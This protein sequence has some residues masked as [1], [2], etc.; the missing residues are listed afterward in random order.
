MPNGNCKGNASKWVLI[1]VKIILYRPEDGQTGLDVHLRDEAV[2]RTQAPMVA[3]FQR[4]KQTISALG[5]EVMDRGEATDIFGNE[6]NE[7]LPGI[8][9]AISQ[10]VDGQDVYPGAEEKAAH[11]L[12]FVIR[13]HP[14]TDGNKRVGSF[15]FL[16][17]LQINGLPDEVRFDN[18]A[19]VTLALLTAAGNPKQKDLRIRL[20]VNLPADSG[21]GS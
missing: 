13:D 2:W 19:L 10:T 4:T 8:P 6:R 15:L 11:L 1:K 21:E 9:G 5:K 17:F 18:K 3:R 7:G 14:F 12:Y 16:Y 20:I